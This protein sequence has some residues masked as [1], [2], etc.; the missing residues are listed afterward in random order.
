MQADDAFMKSETSCNRF[1]TVIVRRTL[2]SAL[3]SSVLW[4]VVFGCMV[5]F[6]ALSYSTIYRTQTDRNSLASAFGAN[7]S[8]S[9]LFG[10]APQLQTVAGFTVFKVWL[11]ISIIGGIWGLL[12]ST[13]LLRGEEESGR[14]EL[15]LMG[16]ATR[17]GAAAQVILGLSGG[18]IVVWLFT[19]L[20]TV[21]A[22]KSPDVNIG[23]QPAL[24]FS[25]SLVVTTLMFIAVGALASQL[26]ATRRQAATYASWVLG[27]SYALRMVADSGGAL[28]WLIW[29][30]PLG[31]VEQLQP[32]VSSYP[33]GLA[34]IF[35]FTIVL[36]IV[37]LYLAGLRDLGASMVGD[38]DHSEANFS[39]LSGSM[40]LTIRLE[41]SLIISWAVALAATGLISGFIADAAGGTL[42]QSSVQTVFTRLGASGTGIET[43]LGVS[44]LMMGV[45]VGFV[46]IGQ[47][48]AAQ[49]EESE[50]RLDQLL[51][52]PLKRIWWFGGKLLVATLVLVTMGVI[53][54]IFS[55]L[56]AVLQSPK[57]SFFASIGAG[58]NIV[59]PAVALL[60]VSA[61]VFGIWP[62]A[63]TFAG[64]G[65]LAW[66]LLIEI[67]G[68][69]G[70]LNHWIFDTSLFHQMAAA[71]AVSINLTSD[72]LMVLGG[73][74]AALAGLG[75]FVRRDICGK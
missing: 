44:F 14:W 22:G 64:Y 18:V 24:F 23:V 20:I 11:T 37:S 8:T 17:R 19:A 3:P 42:S 40:G 72:I 62:R 31:W 6:T 73:L 16:R 13:R 29:V 43:F 52:H 4:G 61:L 49:V 12:I 66:S 56:G 5:A 9:A 32:L 7:I 70:A 57:V 74:A 46:A 75:F 63:T 25:L 35:A 34:P 1:D 38:H 15:L 45:L 21:V 26:A 28:H 27:V 51:V 55:W 47:I 36:V 50:G 54:G 30:S 59:A 71:P 67:V 69:V 60:G 41:R 48:N 68:G 58:L 10:P 2:R 65:V 53:A 39:F 33:I